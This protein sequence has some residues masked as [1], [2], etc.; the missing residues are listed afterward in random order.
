MGISLFSGSFSCHTIS[1]C[2]CRETLWTL[3]S[4]S[5]R[6]DLVLCLS[7]E[8][9]SL[10]L[11]SHTTLTMTHPTLL[12]WKTASHNYPATIKVCFSF[13]AGN[14]SV[15]LKIHWKP[16]TKEGKRNSGRIWNSSI[17]TI[18]SIHI[19][20]LLPSCLWSKPTVS[21]CLSAACVWRWQ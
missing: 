18:P 16:Q 17:H 4:V 15:L 11:S 1:Y 21:V 19:D 20:C 3:Q 8:K 14:C 13:L 9:R 12:L 2:F 5:P 7:S 10:L 6:A